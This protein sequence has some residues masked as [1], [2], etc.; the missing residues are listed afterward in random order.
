MYL[1]AVVSEMALN[2]IAHSGTSNEVNI[3]GVVPCFPTLTVVVEEALRVKFIGFGSCLRRLNIIV[4]VFPKDHLHCA[5][6]TILPPRIIPSPE[7]Q[8]KC[9]QPPPLPTP[10]WETDV[11]IVGDPSKI[12]TTKGRH[13]SQEKHL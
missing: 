13:S 12:T 6:P 7:L 2:G 10:A 3:M 1:S 9:S 4:S 11:C 5:A 8:T